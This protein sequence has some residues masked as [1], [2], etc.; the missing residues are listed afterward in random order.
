VGRAKGFMPAGA[1]WW[2]GRGDGMSR[3]EGVVPAG[4]WQG[5]AITVQDR[6]GKST[7][8]TQDRWN[9]RVGG[10]ESELQLGSAGSW[11]VGRGEA[12]L[13]VDGP[14]EPEARRG[15]EGRKAHGPTRRPGAAR[16]GARREGCGGRGQARRPGWKRCAAA[17]GARCWGRYSKTSAGFLVLQVPG[18]RPGALAATQKPV[19]H[20]RGPAGS[21]AGPLAGR[22]AR[23]L[24]PP[25]A[26]ASGPHLGT[27]P[28][29]AASPAPRAPVST[30][31]AS[32]VRRPPVRAAAA[33]RRPPPPRPP[34]A[35]ARARPP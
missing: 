11:R 28:A 6:A 2:W 20:G 7:R 4:A 21:A 23:C 32:G 25:I 19:R 33:A 14:R 30:R 10:F 22:A 27:R 13:N 1:W 35:P 15:D 24:H 29:R 17:R 34:A 16:W 12:R 3:A 5:C 31:P 8:S 18:E 26:G 9:C